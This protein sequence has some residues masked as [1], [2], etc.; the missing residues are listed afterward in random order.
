M[1]EQEW[2]ECDDIRALLGYLVGRTSNRK[3]RLFG[4]ACCRRIWPL[5]VEE[6]W[7]KPVALAEW[8]AD[9][10]AT[11]EELEAA[12][13]EMRWCLTETVLQ[14]RS[15]A[16]D[17]W[18]LTACSWAFGAAEA[19]LFETPFWN[20]GAAS[21]GAA[22]A[23]WAAAEAAWRGNR[24]TGPEPEARQQQPV[25]RDIFENPY[26]P[27]WVEAAWLTPQVIA[28]AGTIYEERT[29]EDLPVLADTLEEGGCDNQNILNHLREAGPHVRG[30]WAIDLLLGRE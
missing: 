4:C 3:F 11:A 29:F 9:G 16:V 22:N 23:A 26:R 21:R 5:L 24:G 7:R 8:Y 27:G 12:R 15:A 19:V 6:R 18:I 28:L 10:L 17:P 25:L 2:L 13:Q 1:T 30:C 14:P 20:P